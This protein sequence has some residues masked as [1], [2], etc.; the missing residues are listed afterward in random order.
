M[1]ILC[2]LTVLSSGFWFN[3]ACD[4]SLN[5]GSIVPAIVLWIGLSDDVTHYDSSSHFAKSRPRSHCDSSSHLGNHDSGVILEIMT[6]GVIFGKHDWESEMTLR[7]AIPNPDVWQLPL[8]LMLCT[9]WKSN[10]NPDSGRLERENGCTN[11]M[12]AWHFHLLILN[13]VLR[14]TWIVQLGAC[15]CQCDGNVNL[16]ISPLRFK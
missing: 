16:Q 6:P 9:V 1:H 3:R 2:H 7:T 8:T 12:R 4:C 10:P 5:S 15:T 14:S 13:S 11:F